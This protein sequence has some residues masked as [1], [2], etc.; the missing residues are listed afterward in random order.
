MLKS[1]D[2]SEVF[3]N[4]IKMNNYT[5]NIYINRGKKNKNLGVETDMNAFERRKKIR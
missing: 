2:R 3:T 4:K 1:R 5:C